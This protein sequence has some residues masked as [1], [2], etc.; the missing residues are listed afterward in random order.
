MKE[1]SYMDESWWRP[2]SWSIYYTYKVAE[3]SIKRYSHSISSTNTFLPH[4][5]N[6]TFD[7][8]NMFATNEETFML[9]P[10]S[11]CPCLCLIVV[12]VVVVVLD[13]T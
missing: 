7:S 12:V 9:G 11:L 8:Q 5:Q 3:T 10:R 4:E 2:R 13:H 6:I 1:C